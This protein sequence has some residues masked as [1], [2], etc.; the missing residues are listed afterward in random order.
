VSLLL[1]LDILPP[2]AGGGIWGKFGLL[3]SAGIATTVLVA[4]CAMKGTPE[5]TAHLD[6]SASSSAF[7]CPRNSPE[8][9]G[10]GTPSHAA[11]CRV[12]LRDVSQ[13]NARLGSDEAPVNPSGVIPAC[14][15]ESNY[16]GPCPVEAG[17]S[18]RFD[19][20]AVD[21]SGKVVGVGA[22]MVTL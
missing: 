11:E 14:T 9:Q 7:S 12:E 15:V 22:Y 10:Y 13:Q 5:N 16:N 1:G 18:Y 3:P 4:G 17:H 8:L 2:A 19:V 6:V 21:M 20:K